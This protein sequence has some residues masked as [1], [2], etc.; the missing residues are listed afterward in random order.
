MPI[1][2]ESLPTAES[3]LAVPGLLCVTPMASGGNLVHLGPAAGWMPPRGLS[4]WEREVSFVARA[5][6]TPDLG[7]SLHATLPN[8][9]IPPKKLPLAYRAVEGSPYL[10]LT[11]KLAAEARKLGL[12]V[13]TVGV[14][15]VSAGFFYFAEGGAGAAVRAQGNLVE[16]LAASLKPSSTN[17]EIAALQEG[18]VDRLLAFY[19]DGAVSELAVELAD[20]L[21]RLSSDGTGLE[22]TQLEVFEVQARAL[23]SRSARWETSARDMVEALQ[24][25]SSRGDR[26]ARVPLYGEAR[27]QMMRPLKVQMGD[28]TVTLP[29][30]YRWTVIGQP[31]EELKSP[32]RAQP[33]QPV[34]AQPTPSPP[35]TGPS[36]P[37]P[38]QATSRRSPKPGLAA[39]GSSTPKQSSPTADGKPAEAA[40]ATAAPE[41][42]LKSEAK[43]AAPEVVG[44]EAN[45]KPAAEHVERSPRPDEAAAPAPEEPAAQDDEEA[46]AATST[47]E[48][49]GDR[50]PAAAQSPRPAAAARSTG[51]RALLVLLVIA[52]GVAVYIRWHE[53]IA[54]FV[55]QYLHGE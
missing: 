33:A 42:D 20:A 32:E 13:H 16:M 23:S 28:D 48:A 34:P 21:P 12:R 50:E 24:A 15:R 44:R 29:A 8:E 7:R 46:A 30:R 17:A 25:A 35:R 10:A 47:D 3:T 31:R 22:G 14:D 2:A 45:G 1:D 4:R 41:P 49:N 5:D 27:Q 40:Q 9:Q 54:R 36:V 39:E 53:T 11:P 6:V 52:T 38:Q 51:P 19:S 55:W 43:E 18:L 37:R 26:T